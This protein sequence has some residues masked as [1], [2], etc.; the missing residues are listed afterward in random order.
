[1]EY[2]QSFQGVGELINWKEALKDTCQY[3][4]GATLD[5]GA[6][7]DIELLELEKWMHVG[8]LL[9]QQTQQR[10]ETKLIL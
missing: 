3:K 4:N 9:F 2:L 1:M 6:N 10:Q 8:G 5:N 7:L